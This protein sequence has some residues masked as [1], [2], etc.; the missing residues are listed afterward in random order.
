M[1]DKF[2]IIWFNIGFLDGML[3]SDK[4]MCENLIKFIICK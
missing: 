3:W 4:H 2:Q 1:A